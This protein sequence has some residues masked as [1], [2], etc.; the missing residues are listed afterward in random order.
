MDPHALRTLEF[1]KIRERLA[2][3]TSFSA[4]RELA[5]ELTPSSEHRAVV[6]RQRETAEARRLIQMKPRTGLQGA[7]DVRPLAEK[8]AR[9]GILTPDELLE[10]ASTLECARE[11]K[12]SVSRLHETLPCW[13]PSST[14]SSRWCGWSRRS[15]AA[16]TSGRR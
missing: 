11:L 16:S 2:R 8:C 12:A 1:D 3:C 7:H 14:A 10:I 9:G 15:T 6:L 13:R 5:L 4:G